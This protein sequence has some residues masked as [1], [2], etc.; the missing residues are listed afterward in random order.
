MS[1]QIQYEL[2]SAEQSESFVKIAEAGASG[3]RLFIILL[4]ICL[5]FSCN[6]QKNM[7]IKRIIK[8]VIVENLNNYTFSEV[9]NSVYIAGKDTVS[10][11]Y[12]SE[13]DNT[14]SLV[15]FSI[16]KPEGILEYSI[17]EL[18]KDTLLFNYTG[19]KSVKNWKLIDNHINNNTD[20][21]K[22]EI[23]KNNVGMSIFINRKGN[24]I[25][26]FE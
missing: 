24:N 20:T 5:L 2:L 14:G 15:K 7:Q 6:V 19:G 17:E 25:T 3:K 26:I 8:G 16:H 11:R 23:T 22:V 10:V 21:L 12:I 13:Y 18:K 9:P 4:F 1:K